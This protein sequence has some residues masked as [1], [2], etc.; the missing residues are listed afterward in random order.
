MKNR[1]GQHR[2]DAVFFIAAFLVQ[3]LLIF[4][5]EPA[6]RSALPD[7]GDP[8]PQEASEPSGSKNLSPKSAKESETEAFVKAVQQRY[9]AVKSLRAKFVETYESSVLRKSFEESGIVYLARPRCMRW[10]YLDPEEKLFVTAGDVIYFYIKEDNQLILSRLQDEQEQRIPALLLIGGGGNILRDYHA[11]ME[12]K[13]RGKVTSLKLTPIEPGSEYKYFVLDVDSKELSI[14]RI[15]A[16]DASD[17]KTIIRFSDI[18]ENVE[19]EGSLFL[20]KIPDG[21]EIIENL[22]ESSR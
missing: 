8:S 14:F 2:T 4:A 15:T 1:P 5:L 22:G 6:A 10:E 3:A 21:V 7:S 9:E 20:F 18:R 19:V 12:K 11:A 16:V 13:E 17:N